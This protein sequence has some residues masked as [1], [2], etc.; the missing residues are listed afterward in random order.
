[1]DGD[2]LAFDDD[3]QQGV[4]EATNGQRFTFQLSDWRGRGLPGPHIAVRF[5]PRGERAE[6]LINRPEAQLRA[7]ASQ[8][9]PPQDGAGNAVPRRHSGFAI[10][11]ISVA[12]LSMF[13]D[14]LAPLLGLVA[15]VLAVLGLR[16][17]HRAPQRYSGR[18]FCWGAI[19]LALLLA[20]LSVLV[21]T[22]VSV[23]PSIQPP[24]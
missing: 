24:N 3:A 12:F 20:V 2:I 10:A 23:E 19:G 15:A 17:I 22:S 5:T 7:R 13:L 6:Q 11:A 21:D 18:L 1:M 16:Q 8:P 14:G 4:V 9:H